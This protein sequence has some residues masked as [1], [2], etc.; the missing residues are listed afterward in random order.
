[1]RSVPALVGAVTCAIVVPFA[2]LADTGGLGCKVPAVE[3]TPDLHTH[4]GM[5]T[6]SQGAVYKATGSVTRVDK[7]AGN[8]TIAHDPVK[9]LKWPAMT[10]RFGVRD[11][12][13]L[14][15]LSPGKKVEFHFVHQ[16]GHYL[17][18]SVE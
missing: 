17:L 3:P 11:R 9:E 15:R 10:M 14:D 1:M 8:V 7:A 6:T 16:G 13:A 18:T 5:S 4:C 12:S 2:A